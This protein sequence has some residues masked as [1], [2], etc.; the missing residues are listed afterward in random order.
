MATITPTYVYTDNASFDTTE[1]NANI[2]SETSGRG[3]MSESNGGLDNSN[4]NGSFAVQD[5]HIAP[6]TIVRARH[7]FGR[8]SVDYFTE[9]ASPGNTTAEYD[10][11][12]VASCGLRFYIPYNGIILFNVQ[13]FVNFFRLFMGTTDQEQITPNQEFGI[14]KHWLEIGTPTG[15]SRA[16]ATIRAIP[17]SAWHNN[18][19]SNVINREPFMG[20]AV[21][22]HHIVRGATPG[23]YDVQLKLLIDRDIGFATRDINRTFPSDGSP[24][25]KDGVTEEYTHSVYSRVSFGVRNA[26][27]LALAQ[28]SPTVG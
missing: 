23:W 27:A 2:Y 3:I 13:F 18:L 14:I 4:L 19:T 22:M 5:H 20:F 6:E 17:C 26:T 28:A 15:S 1:H 16:D 25:S 8:D 12:N 21:N 11:R 24:G 7:D 10:V 9:E